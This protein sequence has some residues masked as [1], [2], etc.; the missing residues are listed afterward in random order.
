MFIRNSYAS[1]FQSI[2]TLTWEC[3]VI[4]FPFYTLLV[5][6]TLYGEVYSRIVFFSM[7]FLFDLLALGCVTVP[8][9]FVIVVLASNDAPVV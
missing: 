7:S 1:F 4:H 9:T 5:T 8:V 3:G 6:F 2:E